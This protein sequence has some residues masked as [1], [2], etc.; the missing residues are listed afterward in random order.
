MKIFYKLNNGY[1]DVRQIWQIEELN[2]GA[3]TDSPTKLQGRINGIE[4][5]SS[6]QVSHYLPEYREEHLLDDEFV[7]E[8]N[9]LYEAF[10]K[11]NKIGEER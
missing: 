5:K 1:I 9:E 8:Y 10:I 3:L 4:F 6:I 2:I 11:Y 7:K